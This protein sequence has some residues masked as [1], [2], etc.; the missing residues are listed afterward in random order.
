MS[1]TLCNRLS[2]GDLDI[3][4]SLKISRRAKH[5]R[6]RLSHR[7][8]LVVVVPHGFDVSR[9]EWIIRERLPWIQSVVEKISYRPLDRNE[10]PRNMVFQS[11][12]EEWRVISGHCEGNV[13][14]LKQLPGRIL[15]LATASGDYDRKADLLL[16]WIRR[17]AAKVLLPKLE[18]VAMRYGF[19]YRKAAVRHQK[20]RWG[21]CS[22]KG[23][24]SLNMKLLFLPP[25]LVDYI[26]LHELCHTCVMDHSPGFWSLFEQYMPDCRVYDRAMKEADRYVPPF[27]R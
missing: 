7:D 25:E 11:I 4:Y 10:L 27:A 14:S 22:S 1:D 24:I 8:G 15:L 20:T 23:T 6:L 12:G 3:S 16:D 2:A 19:P 9:I 26:I 13:D 5:V 21:S 18:H 17:K